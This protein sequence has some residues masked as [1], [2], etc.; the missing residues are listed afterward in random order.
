MAARQDFLWSLTFSPSSGIIQLPLETVSHPQT[1]AEIQENIR[2]KLANLPAQLIN[3]LQTMPFKPQV[4]EVQPHVCHGKAV[5]WCSRST[6]APCL[7]LSLTELHPQLLYPL[8]TSQSQMHTLLR[9]T[10]LQLTTIS[11]PGGKAPSSLSIFLSQ[12]HIHSTWFLQFSIVL[13][14]LSKTARCPQCLDDLQRNA[15]LT[16]SCHTP[17]RPMELR[18][19]HDAQ[20]FCSHRR[21]RVI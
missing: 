1:L 17:P 6:G 15:A 12:T 9:G 11:L 18:S 2:Q 7:K 20:Q 3:N 10:S 5:P 16:C 4:R 21:S 13:S 14:P 19:T 8:S